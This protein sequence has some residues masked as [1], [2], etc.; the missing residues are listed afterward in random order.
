M[1]RTIVDFEL[2]HAFLLAVVVLGAIVIRASRLLERWLTER[3]ST[4][5]DSSRDFKGTS[6][7]VGAGEV[8]QWAPSKFK[9]STPTAYPDW[10][11]KYTK[12]LPYRPF[13]YGPNYFVTMG[14]RNIRYEDWIELDNQYPRYHDLKL[15]RIQ[16]R[17]QKCCRT[18]PDAYEA[19]VELLQELVEYLPARYPTLYQRTEC[20]I[21]NLL[22]GEEID[23]ISRPLPEDP[24]QSCGRLTQDDL[25]IMM[26]GKDGLYYLKA[27]AII[28]PGFWRLEDKIGMPL[29][30]IHTSAGVPH[31]REKLERG[32][33]NLFRRMKVGDVFARNNYFLQVDDDLAWSHSIGSEDGTEVTWEAV[34]K[35]RAIQHHHFRSERQTLHRMPKTGAI[36]FT[37][38]TYFHPITEIAQEDYVPGRLASAIRSWTDDVSRYKGKAHYQA[39]LLEYLDA[40]HQKQLGR[41]LKV[42]EEDQKRVYPW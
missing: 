35:T 27:G 34:D 36:V 13:R 42:E 12:P 1:S 30:E 9:Y 7:G 3:R 29:A 5:I 16:E 25:A 40:E 23:T 24:M 41:G 19:S 21:C 22:T 33:N 18:L 32:M 17:G 37:I 28:L 11:V 14:I 4:S 38:H 26:E 2:K 20:G 10:S 31:Y 15:R 8:P 39:V 6:A